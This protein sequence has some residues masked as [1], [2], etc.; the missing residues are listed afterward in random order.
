MKYFFLFIFVTLVSGCSALSLHEAKT[1]MAEI[2]VNCARIKAEKGE[3]HPDCKTARQ[4]MRDIEVARARADLERGSYA[5]STVAITHGGFDKHGT[6]RA[7]THIGTKLIGITTISGPSRSGK[8][9][10]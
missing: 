10:R 7:S 4:T 3:E 8:G 1:L 5:T 6:F 9:K 2:E